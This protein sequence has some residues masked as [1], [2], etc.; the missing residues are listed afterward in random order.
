MRLIGNKTRLLSEIERFLRDRG[1]AG[2]TLIDIFS[3]TASVSRHFKALGFRILANDRLSACYTKAVQAVEVSRPPAFESLEKKYAPL[4]RSRAFRSDLFVHQQTLLA[5]DAE[6]QPRRRG[7][8]ASLLPLE[9]AVRLLDRHVP[10]REGLIH[11]SFSPGGPAGRMY[12]TEE[13]ARR[14]DGM[15]EFLRENHLEGVLGHE[16]LHVLL[17]SVIDAADRVANISGTYGAYLKRWQANALA[18]LSLRLPDIVPSPFENRAH[19]EDSNELI[20]RLQGDVLYVDPP[21]NKRQYAANYHVLDVI[22]EYPRLDDPPAYEARLYGKT[23]LRP[24]KDLR[25]AYSV[26]PSP[27]TKGDDALGAMT[28]LILASR[29]DHVLVSYNEEGLL[30]REELGAIL[31]RFSGARS[32]DFENDMRTVLYKRFRSDSDRPGGG[33]RARR[34][35]KV[36]DGKERNEI[37][38][39]LLFA[40]RA[41]RRA[42]VLAPRAG[43]T[44]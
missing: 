5:G 25:S 23:G 39:W 20:R 33:G 26:P 24:W 15:L 16:E 42:R 14:L 2:G 43:A 7:R 3:G 44:S 30:T 35:Y 37:S 27:R 4:L 17:S 18:P 32:F 38:E 9:R 12:F 21:Y 13:N 41:R 10:P 1:I 22:A 34:L 36:L 29:A 8:A 40:S 6:Q 19:Q 31:S 28:D 11:R